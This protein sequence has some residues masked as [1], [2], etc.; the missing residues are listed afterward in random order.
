LVTSATPGEG[1]S[2][3]AA[4]LAICPTRG[5]IGLADIL[6]TR[7]DW[8]EAV[9]YIGIDNLKI[10]LA[11]APPHNPSELLSTTRMKNLMQTWKECFDIIIF[12]MYKFRTMYETPISAQFPLLSS[13]FTIIPKLTPGM[14]HSRRCQKSRKTSAIPAT[15]LVTPLSIFK[16]RSLRG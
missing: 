4:N 2:T 7:V 5:C 8:K 3:T 9:Q 10:L 16:E 11:G 15:D 1:K 13:T 12:E 14:G 6:T